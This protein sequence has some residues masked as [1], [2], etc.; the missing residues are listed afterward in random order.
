MRNARRLL[1]GLVALLLVT[2]AQEVSAA[3]K[4][5]LER[6]SGPG[7]FEGFELS[8]LPIWCFTPKDDAVKDGV[9]PAGASLSGFLC[10]G[11]QTAPDRSVFVTF[12]FSDLESQR[13]NLEYDPA[14]TRDTTVGLQSYVF[15]LEVKL[16]PGLDV[17]VGLGVNRFSGQVFRAF[18]RVSL[19]PLRVVFRPVGLLFPQKA[20]W[21]KDSKVKLSLRDLIQVKF[22][23]VLFPK[24]FDALD[25][26]SIG[27]FD[28]PSEL[29]VGYSVTLG[30]VLW[31]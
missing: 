4:G 13:N 22:R 26:G 8:T 15:S 29:L 3:G 18:T 1:G 21:G 7:P 11:Y 9:S 30:V 14:E 25:F 17:G 23:T 31:W 12:T 16:H 6:L 2:S 24:G 10:S 28:E 20:F 5:W 19:E 27:T